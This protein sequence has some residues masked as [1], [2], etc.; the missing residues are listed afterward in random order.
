VLAKWRAA[1][2]SVS[3]VGVAVGG[4]AAETKIWA[5]VRDAL[6]DEARSLLF[7]TRLGTSAGTLN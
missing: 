2:V 6:H 7:P 3:A 4:A 1:G 5:P